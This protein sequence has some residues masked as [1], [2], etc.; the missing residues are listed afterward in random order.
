MSGILEKIFKKEITEKFKEE[1]LLKK[2]GTCKSLKENLKLLIIA[3]THDCLTND[4]EMIQTISIDPNSYDACLLLGDISGK[5]METILKYISKD[6]TY[7]ILGNHD[8]LDK[9]SYYNIE[10]INGKVIEINGLKIA[11]LQGS[12]KYKESEY[13]MYTHEE[14]IELVEKMEQADILI[15]HD[16]PFIQNNNDKAH[17]GLIGITNY[18]Y[19]NHIAINI[20]G[21]LH[22]N[23]L[24]YLKNGTKVIGVYGCKIIEI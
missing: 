17:D 8:S 4:E 15:S 19:K 22:Q 12:Y 10:N 14:S 20:H 23:D 1:K 21:H 16:R 18:I 5:D 6:K 11:G 9:L 7:G 24:E 3:D 13:A 2:H